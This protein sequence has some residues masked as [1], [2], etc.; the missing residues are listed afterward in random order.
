LGI[1]TPVN[2]ERWFV[3]LA[4]E[5]YELYL[6]RLDAIN[7]DD[8]DGLLQRATYALDGGCDHGSHGKAGDG[9]LKNGSDICSSMST[10]TSRN[11][12]IS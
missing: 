7:A 5:I 9:D 12:S 10:K 6:D 1:T 3:D 8:F 11:S 2:I 4:V